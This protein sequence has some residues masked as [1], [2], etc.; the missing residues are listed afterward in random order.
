MSGKSLFEKI[1]EEHAVEELPGGETLLYIDRH[2][3]YEL[4]C[5]VALRRLREAGR[6]VRRADRTWAVADHMLS[7]AP[8]RGPESFPP[9][10]PYLRALERSS[11]DAG[12]PYVGPDDPR[13]GIVHVVAA[14]TGVVLPG[15]TV[16]CGDS[17]TCTLG[18]LGAVAFGIGTGGIEQ[19]LVTQALP[20]RRPPVMAVQVEG[21][22]AS[23]VCAK[24]LALYL[25]GRLGA[26]GAAGHAVEFMGSAVRALPMEGR[27]TLC[28]LA[29]EFGARFALIA[30][31]EETASWL[32][33]AG[34]DGAGSTAWPEA[35]CADAHFDARHAFDIDGLAPQITW[36]T[37]PAQVCAVT[38]AVPDPAS[39]GAA[40]AAAAERALDYMGLRPGQPLRGLPVDDV[41]IGSCTNGRLSDLRAAAAV[42]GS[43]RVAPGV[44]AWVVPGS[45]TVARA[46]QAEGLHE[47]F[48]AAGF[49]WREPG[50]SLCVAVNGEA[51]PA[52]HRAVSTS[53]R[54]FEHRQGRGARTHLASPASA[55]A[56]AIAGSIADPRE[57]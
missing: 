21:G 2:L 3:L 16:A 28:N 24:D 8:G 17:H 51:V 13:Q 57:F 55:A 50:C 14:E 44:R 20:V 52:G 6:R 36:G 56:A 53:N 34:V 26:E 11:R 40:Q 42:V 31:D 18:A 35:A 25:I 33:A 22:L 39:L 5:A 19:V 10:I 30:P 15:M 49:E 12:I 27:F 29:V 9:A 23:V 43:R 32:H 38:D 41:F 46:A 45:R 48:L 7:T 54:N 4:T 47:I 1:W 37:G